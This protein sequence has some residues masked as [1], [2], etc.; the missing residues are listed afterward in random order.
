MNVSTYVLPSQA[1]PPEIR[2]S[3]FGLSAAMGKLGALV[4]ASAFVPINKAVGFAGTYVVCAVISVLGILCTHAYVEPYWTD[5]WRCSLREE[6]E[7]EDEDT[8]KRKPG[9]SSGGDGEVAL[10][11]E[12]Y[13]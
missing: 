12:Q 10:L 4:G 7:D 11:D 8:N 2:S 5:S 9:A 3:F 6:D 1:Y 13:D